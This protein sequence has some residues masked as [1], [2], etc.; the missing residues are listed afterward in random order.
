MIIITGPT[1]IG[2]K[3]RCNASVP[4]NFT[5]VLSAKYTRPADAKPP[6]VVATPQV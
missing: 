6:I 5:N 4:R 3:M 1:T 2:G